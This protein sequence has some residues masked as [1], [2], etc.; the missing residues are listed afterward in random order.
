VKAHVPILT[1]PSFSVGLS[2][3]LSSTAI[4]RFYSESCPGRAM[5]NGVG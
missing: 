1:A 2:F 4:A 5:V 3:V